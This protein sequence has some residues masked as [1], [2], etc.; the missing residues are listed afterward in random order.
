MENRALL[1]RKPVFSRY[2]RPTIAA[3]GQLKYTIRLTTFSIE[4][5]AHS[6]VTSAGSSVQVKKV[7]ARSNSISAMCVNLATATPGGTSVRATEL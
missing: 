4:V 6:W 5:T 3:P 2:I 1:R 7:L